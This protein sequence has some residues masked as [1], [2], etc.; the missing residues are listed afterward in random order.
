[1]QAQERL[2]GLVRGL[3][4]PVQLLQTATQRL[5]DWSERLMTSLPAMLDKKQQQ[6][7]LLATHLRPQLL[8]TDIT[9]T[10]TRLEEFQ[11][12]MNAAWQRSEQTKMEKLRSL[13]AL[14][15]SVNYQRVLERGFA[16]V[17]DA[18]GKLITSAKEAKNKDALSLTFKDGEVRVKP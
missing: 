8:L 12:R 4:R 5:D 17:K 18:S 15:E 7:A 9:K 2:E 16:L 11:Q 10:Q 1:M 14:L 3:P 6:L 13:S